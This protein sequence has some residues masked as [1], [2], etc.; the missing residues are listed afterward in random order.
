MIIIGKQATSILFPW[1]YRLLTSLIAWKEPNLIYQSTKIPRTSTKDTYFVL[2][3]S[4]SP[5]ILQLLILFL[6][7]NKQPHISVQKATHS[8]LSFGAWMLETLNKHVYPILHRNATSTS[9][10]STHCHPHKISHMFQVR[11]SK[12]VKL[13]FPFFLFLVLQMRFVF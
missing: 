11:G 10:V 9:C 2:V 5:L 12:N 8:D 7:L 1:C 3:D 6:Q 13:Q 4:S